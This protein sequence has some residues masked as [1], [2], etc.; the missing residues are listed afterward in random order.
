MFYLLLYSVPLRTLSLSPLKLVL[1]IIHVQIWESWVHNV[2]WHLRGY[3]TNCSYISIWYELYTC[4]SLLRK[5]NLRKNHW[6]TTSSWI[7]RA[8]DFYIIMMPVEIVKNINTSIELC[9]EV[10]VLPHCSRQTKWVL[11]RDLSPYSK[12][13]W[14]CRLKLAVW[15]RTRMVFDRNLVLI[16]STC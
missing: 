5:P 9:R 12:N 8:M 3:K 15:D 2:R 14:H 1:Q 13:Q 16:L 4:R 10:L 6:K 7:T 11:D